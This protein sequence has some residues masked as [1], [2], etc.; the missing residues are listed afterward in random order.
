CFYPL[1]AVGQEQG[2]ALAGA[3][4]EIGQVTGE[5]SRS[6]LEVAIG[7]RPPRVLKGN[8]RRARVGLPAQQF[9]Y[10]RHEIGPQHFILP[11]SAAVVVIPVDAASEH[12]EPTVDADDLSGD[13]AAAI[14]SEQCHQRRDVRGATE[15][16][17]GV[18]LDE[19]F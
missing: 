5:I 3:D 13:P 8:L 2:D 19:L 18:E 12:A 6:P 9:A 10:R 17:Q 15:S 7:D 14:G 11:W 4:A 16:A 1:D